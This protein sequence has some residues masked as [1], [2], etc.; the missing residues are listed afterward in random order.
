M[1]KN[2]L[3]KKYVW[4]LLKLNKPPIVL[5][6]YN[7]INELKCTIESLRSCD[8]LSNRNWYIFSDGYKNENDKYK[9]LQIRKFFKK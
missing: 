9:V 1:N 4:R 5:F 2:F 3:C 6:V 8:G 7:R